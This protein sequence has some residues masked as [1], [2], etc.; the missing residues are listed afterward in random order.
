MTKEFLQRELRRRGE[1]N[2]RQEFMCSF[3]EAND[4]VF[5]GSLIEAAMQDDD[6]EPLWPEWGDV[7]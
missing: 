2:F 7:A 1:R 5:H 3:E 4:A 6:V